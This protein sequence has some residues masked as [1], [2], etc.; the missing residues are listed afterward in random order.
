M[1]WVS[2]GREV[3]NYIPVTS[4]QH[5]YKSDTLSPLGAFEPIEEY[6]DRIKEGDGKRFLRNKVLF[7][8]RINP[9]LQ[10]SDLDVLDLA[11]RLDEVCQAIRSW[12]RIPEAPAA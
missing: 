11:S 4:L 7:A 5:L 3:E 2:A 10:R 1:G 9:T 12:S 6:L 8:E